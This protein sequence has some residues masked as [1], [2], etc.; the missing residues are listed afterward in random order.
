VASLKD[1]SLPENAMLEEFFESPFRIQEI[2][3]RPYGGMIV[4]F[5]K[6]LQEAGYSVISAR[7]HIRTVEHLIHWVVKKGICLKAFAEPDFKVFIDHLKRCRCPHFSRSDRRNVEKGTRLFISHLHRTGVLADVQTD[8]E[9]ID[10][11]LYELF[12]QWMRQQRGTNEK[13][14]HNYKSTIKELLKKLGDDASRYSARALRQFI[15]ESSKGS[16]W[17]A[18]KR[19]TTSIRMFLRFLIAEEKC[20][21]GLDASIPSIAHWRLSS[22]PQYIQPNEVEKVIDICDP[23]THRG[24]RDRAILLLLARLGLRAGD[25][26]DMRIEDIEWTEGWIQVSGKSRRE[27]RLPLTQEIG[28]AIAIYLTRWRPPGA[29]NRLFLCT[30]APHRPFASHAAVS[31]MV[32]RALH[33]AGVECAGRNGAHVFRHTAA[34]SMLRQGASLQEIASVLRHASTKTTEIYAKV[35]FNSLLDIAQPWPEVK[36][37]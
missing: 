9:A 35:D 19:S 25:I 11:D 7:R 15:L 31:V 1:R 18:A 16:G 32:R 4:E 20:P 27:V 10:A 12:C 6:E 33:R 28:Q 3:N 22:L 24:S 13:T 5:S 23:C 2:K 36:T 34:T 26:V 30:L 14:L 21:I 37:C 17:A 29:E 8:D